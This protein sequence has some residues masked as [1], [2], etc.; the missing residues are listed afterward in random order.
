MF[1]SERVDKIIYT[2]ILGIRSTPGKIKYNYVGV[3]VHARVMRD[4]LP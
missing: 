2:N 1:I 4:S 3:G